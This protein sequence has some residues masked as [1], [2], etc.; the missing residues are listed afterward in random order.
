[1]LGG[2]S[3]RIAV[4]VSADVDPLEGPLAGQHLVEDRAEGED[5]GAMVDRL[6]A[7]LL[8]RHVAGGAHHHAGIGSCSQ[9]RRGAVGVRLALRQFREAEV[10]NL[11][12]AVFGDEQ[13]LGLEVAMNDA[14][15]VRRRQSMRD[16][17]AVFDGFAN[18]HGAA[19]QQFARAC[20]PPATPRRD[21]AP[22]KTAEMVNGKDIGMVEGGGRLRL[23]LKATQ[24]VRIT[25]NKRRAGP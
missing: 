2:S 11:D 23:L 19:P 5:I 22:S 25:R 12:P 24:P 7:H 15:V 1:M 21:R 4:I 13:V 17:N 3:F 16:L 14:L 10:Q 20:C 9:R 6:A 8:G 18:R